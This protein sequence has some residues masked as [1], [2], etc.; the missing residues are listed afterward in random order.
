MRLGDVGELAQ[1]G[2]GDPAG[3]R[4]DADVEAA[5]LLR[6]ALRCGRRCAGIRRR[7]VD[8]LPA[9][10]LALEHLA[11]P[12]RAPV[13]DQELQP[14]AGAQPPV[15]VVAEDPDHAGPD[16]RHLVQRHPGAEPLGQHRVGGQPAADPQ[17]EARAVLGMHHAEERDVV[18]L[19]RHVGQPGDGRLELAG[20]FENAWSPT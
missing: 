13:G 19:V 14:G 18:G 6:G 8:Q 2:P 4:R 17:V 3:H 11:E 9:Q 5:V 12:L 10:V 15:S 20:R 16:L 1:H 7:A